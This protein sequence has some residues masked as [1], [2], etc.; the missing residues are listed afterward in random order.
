MLLICDYQK[1][2]AGDFK[3]K[4]LLEVHEKEAI[5]PETLVSLWMKPIA[6]I[7]EAMKLHTRSPEYSGSADQPL[8]P[9]VT[10]C[11]P[12]RLTMRIQ[13]KHHKAFAFSDPV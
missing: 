5:F 6:S 2:L 12:E 9:P 4:A 7:F 11:K 10:V 8:A 3:Q 13:R 1:F